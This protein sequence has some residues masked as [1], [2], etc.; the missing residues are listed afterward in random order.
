[1]T[2]VGERPGI[3][4]VVVD[5]AGQIGTAPG[6]VLLRRRVPQLDLLPRM[7]AVAC[8]AGHNTVCES[9]YHGVPLV[10]APIRDDQSVIAQQVT[11]AGAA[12]RLRFGRAQAAHIGAALDTVLTDHVYRNNAHRIGESFRAAGGAEAAAGHLEVLAGARAKP[13]VA[14]LALA[15]KRPGPKRDV[16]AFA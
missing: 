10:V 2:A 7:A 1:V 9:L 6:N 11:D 8:H 15:G 13:G 12:I 16:A 3:K 5:P 4:A 14:A